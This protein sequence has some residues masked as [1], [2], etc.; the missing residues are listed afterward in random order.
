MTEPNSK[1]AL[2]EEA[3]RAIAERYILTRLTDPYREM[4][5]GGSLL[6]NLEVDIINGHLRN[7]KVS[8]TF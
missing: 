7:A 4:P 3:L 8:V 6:T 5:H 2:N 1:P